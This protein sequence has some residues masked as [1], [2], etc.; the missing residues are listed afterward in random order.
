MACTNSWAFLASGRRVK[1]LASANTAI[2]ETRPR[3]S[4]K[5]VRCPYAILKTIGPETDGGRR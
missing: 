2:L 4:A 3:P 5:P 1:T